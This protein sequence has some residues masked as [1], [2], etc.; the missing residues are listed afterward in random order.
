MTKYELK[1]CRICGSK[2]KQF[3]DLGNSHPPEEFRTKQELK[4]PI[5]TVPLGL[6]YCPKCGQVQLSHEMPAD[7]MYKQNYFY[8]YSITK[9][10]DKHYSELLNRIE[11]VK[12]IKGSIFVDI[13]SN[14]G[15]L[16]EL[17]KEKGAKIQGVDPSP[18]PIRIAREKG[19]P[20]I[21]SYFGKSAAHKILIDRGQ[22]D[23]ISCNNVFD[24]VSD[25]NKFMEGISMLLVVDGIFVIE[26]PYFLTFYKTLNHTVYHQ[27]IDYI[28]IKPF[29]KFF[30]SHG[31]E[32]FDCERI[33]YH[34]GSIRLFV[35][36]KGAHKVSRHVRD[37]IREEE[38]TV[39]KNEARN[40][41]RFAWRLLN[42]MDEM[43]RKITELKLNGATIAGV[44]MT[45]KG[46]TLLYYSDIGPK[47]I[48]FIT[49]QS[50]LK[51]GRYTPSGIPIVAESELAK[52]QPDYAIL[53]AWNFSDEL[54]KKMSVYTK[55]GGKFLAV[56]PRL[57]LLK[58][59]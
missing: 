4:R 23:I 38:K 53:L 35:G 2:V 1:E 48:D 7:M 54:F 41:E 21:G 37:F 55:K 30:E 29:N 36:F 13:G 40:L 22:A 57:K 15:K 56:V 46:N 50:E 51:V 12:T 44:G 59:R 47:A 11:E 3:L 16:L 49:E 34:G 27:Q 45:A 18:K 31:M 20:T 8:D 33:P 42:Q 5:K 26:D 43:V 14:T 32:I 6:S 24:H 52:R 17:A 25:L 9:T 19:I 58:V 10:A 28:L 39:L